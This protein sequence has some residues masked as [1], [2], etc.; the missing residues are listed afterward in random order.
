MRL[1]ESSLPAACQEGTRDAYSE[2]SADDPGPYLMYFLGHSSARPARDHLSDRTERPCGGV[3]R[4]DAEQRADAADR[5]G[6]CLRR[7]REEPSWPLV[8]REELALISVAPYL[9]S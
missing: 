3:A 6:E 2:S 7:D 4:G 9:R 8:S 5:N 1:G